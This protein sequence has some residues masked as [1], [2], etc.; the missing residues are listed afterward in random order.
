MTSPMIK[1]GDVYETNW[2]SWPVRVVA[3]DADVVMY[4]AWWPHK[5]AWGMSNL[6]GSFS[7]Y[8]LKRRYFEAHTRYLRSESLTEQE[9]KVHRP[10]L[11]FAFAQC[12]DLSW[13]ETWSSINVASNGQIL[14]TPAIY[15]APFGPRDSSKP[16]VLVQS[17]NGEFFTEKELL[18]LAKEIQ[19]PYLGEKRLTN[20]VGIYR[21]G[22]KKRIPSYYLWGAR[23]RLDSGA[24]DAG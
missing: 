8:R 13:Y 3:L 23:S 7:Y 22:I 24:A 2:T 9:L 16:S 12:N 19:S 11:P 20:G 6:L 21:S 17:E 5:N 4:D 18:A 10:E 1:P 14:A 15:I